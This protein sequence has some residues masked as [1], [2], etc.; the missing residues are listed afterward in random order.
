M[1]GGHPLRPFEQGSVCFH[2]ALGPT[3]EGPLSWEGTFVRAT[4]DPGVV[5]ARVFTAPGRV[6]CSDVRREPGP[7]KPPASAP[8]GILIWFLCQFF[9][10]IIH[11]LNQLFKF[12]RGIKQPAPWIVY[13]RGSR[14][15]RSSVLGTR[16]VQAERDALLPRTEPSAPSTFVRILVRTLWLSERPCVRPEAGR[17]LGFT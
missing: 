3:R 12:L 16:P 11:I 8:H 14:R 13:S 4:L 1:L 10:F 2:F 17:A 6:W 15:F 5:T 9:I 7:S